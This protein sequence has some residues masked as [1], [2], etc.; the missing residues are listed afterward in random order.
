VASLITAIPSS[1]L[2][3]AMLGITI[4]GSET[5]SLEEACS[6]SGVSLDRFLRAM[7]E[8]DWNDELPPERALNER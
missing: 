1:A 2:V 7:D 5:K 8:I 4:K 6:D 3:F